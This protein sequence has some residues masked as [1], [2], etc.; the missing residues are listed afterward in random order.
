MDWPAVPGTV[1][2]AMKEWLDSGIR[3]P[4]S[5]CYLLVYVTQRQPQEEEAKRKEKKKNWKA[6]RVSFLQIQWWYFS[7]FLC[8]I[9]LLNLLHKEYRRPL[10][11]ILPYIT[12]IQQV[13][14]HGTN[15]TFC[16]VLFTCEPR[17]VITFPKSQEKK[18]T[19]GKLLAL[20]KLN[21]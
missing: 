8:R 6:I 1:L 16:P 10:S 20:I 21:S 13:V 2:E 5:A 17:M 12:R 15:P 11:A 7:Y 14:P 18:W 4:R 9:L 19:Q 3:V